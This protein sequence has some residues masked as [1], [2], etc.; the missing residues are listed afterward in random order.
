MYLLKFVN[1]NY[2]NA[3]N[4]GQSNNTEITIDNCKTVASILKQVNF[5]AS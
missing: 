1:S 2:D 4:N 3:T 5:F